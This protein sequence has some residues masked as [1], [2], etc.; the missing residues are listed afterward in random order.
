GPWIALVRLVAGFALLWRRPSR[1]KSALAA[2]APDALADLGGLIAP[3]VLASLAAQAIGNDAAVIHYAWPPLL[4]VAGAGIG[5]LVPCATAG[6]AIAAGLV[7]PL[8]AAAAGLLVTAGLVRLPRREGPARHMHGEQPAR[9]PAGF[10]SALLAVALIAIACRGPAGLVNPRLLPLDAA[11]AV[12]A[13]AGVRSR[14][15]A[16]RAAPLLGVGLGCALVAGYDVPQSIVTETTLDDAYPGQRIDFTGVA[17]VTGPGMT[18]QRFAISCCRLDAT[19]VAI[20]L[21]RPL[22]FRDGTWIDVRGSF[23]RDG[24]ALRVRPDRWRAIPAPADPFVYR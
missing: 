5:A 24:V 22:A 11:A 6:V 20:R 16:L 2:T 15:S 23:V 12:L 14:S 8:P 3:S 13:L 4:A 10:A 1:P 7:H 19:A 18:L 9:R 21:T 17:H